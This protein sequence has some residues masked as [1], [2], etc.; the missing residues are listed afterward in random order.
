MTWCNLLFLHWRLPESTIRHLV[1]KELEIDTFD[2]SAWVALVP[3]EMTKT[4]FKSVPPLPGLSQFY[5]CNVRTYVRHGS[6]SGVWFFSLDAE[7]LLPVL[8]GRWLWSLNYVHSRFTVTEGDRTDYALTR[9]SSRRWPP[10]STRI[11][12]TGGEALPTSKPG[13]LEHFLTERYYLFT[14]RRGQIMAGRIA[15]DPWP[16]RK[17][18]LHELDD[19]LV[20]AAGIKVE[21]EPHVM[22]SDSIDVLGY[23]LA[24]C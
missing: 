11:A 22:M 4:S 3:F 19:S 7:R 23:K 24:R 2:G 15:H 20:A 6:T 5:E 8:G 12:W 9:R 10:G 17:A 1:P 13:S 14:K 21:G 18:E 16:L